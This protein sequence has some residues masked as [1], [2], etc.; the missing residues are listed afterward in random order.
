MTTQQTSHVQSTIH[1]R[2][3]I[4]CLGSGLGL[5][6][7]GYMHWP[8]LLAAHA[9]GSREQDY[10]CILLWMKGGP[11]QFETFAPKPE[12]RHSGETRA[13][14]TSVA[15]IEIAENLPLTAR[16]MQDIC[17]IRSMNSKEGS[18][19]RA[20]FLLHTGN[21]PTPSVRHPALGSIVAQQLTRTDHDLPAFV[22]IGAQRRNS[23]GA[24]FLGVEYE[25]FTMQR[26]DAAPRNTELPVAPSRFR[27]RMGLLNQ[28]ES[29]INIP[30]LENQVIEQRSLYQEARNLV[31]SPD[32]AVFD[33]QQEPATMQAAY[34]ESSF[35]QGCLLARRLVEA[36]VTFV[37]IELGNWDTHQDNFARTRELCQ[38]MDRSYAQLLEDLKQRGM[39]ER[40]LVIWMGEF[41]RTPRINPRAGRDHYPK[42]FSLALAGAG[43]QGGQVIGRT[44]AG[45]V[46]VTERPVGVSDLFQTFCQAL[47]IDADH[48]NMSP[49]GRPIKVVE[50]GTPVLEVF[51]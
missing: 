19:P 28:L 30:G 4:R 47:K 11:S 22:K 42:A 37:E 25:P 50:G 32:M 14:S 12:H 18:H 48:E 31:L 46:E 10:A 2:D 15:G 40:T 5:F 23:S 44:D 8:E 38:Q 6:S 43:V 34:G 36:G 41:G 1:R 35:G 9:T 29:E 17:V 49:I 21:I 16:K 27:R 39:L 45:G 51:G 26:A 24:G 13:I 33:I 7:T 3:V 20:S